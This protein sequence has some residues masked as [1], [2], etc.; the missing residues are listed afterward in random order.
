MARLVFVKS[1]PKKKSDCNQSLSVLIKIGIF[2]FFNVNYGR[3]QFTSGL[4]IEL[5]KDCPQLLG[6]V[7]ETHPH[8]VVQSLWSFSLLKLNNGL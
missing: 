1:W 5:T 7:K 4:A 3:Q 2:L 6:N 8:F